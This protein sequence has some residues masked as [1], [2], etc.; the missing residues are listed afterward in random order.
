ML[1]PRGGS[2]TY[3]SAEFAQM[4][5]SMRELGAAGA[6][7]FVFGVL[8]LREGRV[9]VDVERCRVLVQ[10]AREMGNGSSGRRMCVFHRAFDEVEVEAMEEE[11]KVLIELG[12][13]GV[14]TSGGQ[15]GA[16]EGAEVL[17]GLVR[18]AGGRI[19]V[20][21][22]GGVRKE[23]LGSL[24]RGTGAGWFHSSAVVGGGEEASEEEIRALVEGLI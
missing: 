9:R 1:R 13:E 23:N 16:V 5:A 4:Q 12:F 17:E 3:T 21:V 10:M 24:V 15:G 18:C 7:G 20:L 8:A 11:L 6:D 14:L 19:E 2:F 22:G